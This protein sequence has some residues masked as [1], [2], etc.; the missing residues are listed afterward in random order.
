MKDKAGIIILVLGLSILVF[1]YTRCFKPHNNNYNLNSKTNIDIIELSA[2]DN[3][4]TSTIPA[5]TYEKDFKCLARI[6]YFE[7]SNTNDDS[8]QAIAQVVMNRLNHKNNTN[9]LVCDLMVENNGK[10]WQFSWA[11][12]EENLSKEI[13][14]EFLE[15]MV[16]LVGTIYT[17]DYIVPSLESAMFFKLCKHKPSTGNHWWRKLKKIKA[18]DGHCFYNKIV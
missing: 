4:L 3:Y 2:L 7:A 6:I 13:P 17:E 1:T 18:I 15:D 16:Y 10:V 9:A 14:E 11:K 5:F 8:K 12:E